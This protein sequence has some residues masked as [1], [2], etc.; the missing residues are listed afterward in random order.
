MHPF[1]ARPLLLSLGLL[2]SI[3]PTACSKPAG[4][5][6]HYQV[7]AEVMQLPER[8]NGDLLIRH[9][10]IDGFA[11]RDGKKVGMDPMSMPFPVAEGLS[12]AGFQTGD[13]VRC[14]LEVDW[15]QRSPVKIAAIE[16]LPAGT[17]LT[18]R[19]ARP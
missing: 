12:L 14:T 3:L 8:P 1:F 6:Q 2:A 7:R 5:V 19:E 11:D 10:A 13:V 9:E 4:P 18:F 17:K 16:K 15:Q